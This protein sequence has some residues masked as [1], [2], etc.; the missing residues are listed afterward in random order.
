MQLGDGDVLRGRVDPGD[1]ETQAR[2]GLGDQAAAAAD[3]QQ[4]QPA[5][6]R[7]PFRVAAEMGGEAVADEPDPLRIELMQGPEGARRVPPAVRHFGELGDFLR[8]Y[9]LGNGV[10]DGHGGHYTAE[11]AESSV[12]ETFFWAL[13]SRNTF[14]YLY[15][16]RDPPE[17][18][19]LRHSR[20]AAFD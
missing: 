12:P 14:E 19:E 11:K 2:H 18:L 1:V 3:V 10:C 4:A 15:A 20:K 7:R 9:G 16:R 17:T 5:E 8:G 6:R 13:V